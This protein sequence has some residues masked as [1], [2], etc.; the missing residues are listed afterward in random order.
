MTAGWSN[1]GMNSAPVSSTKRGGVRL[2]EGLALQHDLGTVV[3]GRLQ[4]R[5]RDAERHEDGRLDAELARR[6]GDALRVITGRGGDHAARPVCLVELREAVERAAQLVRAGALQ[7]LAFQVDGWRTAHLGQV[8]GGF[9]GGT[10]RHP[11][12]RIH[13]P[14]E[15][16]EGQLLLGQ[17][18]HA[19][20]MFLGAHALPFP[21]SRRATVRALSRATRYTSF[22]RW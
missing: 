7:V 1:G 14:L 10:P 11:V 20:A 18:C 12:H 2:V 22:L 9:K 19:A 16:V 4:L 15:V 17:L 21:R 8:A 6:V 13:R 3:A 5:Q